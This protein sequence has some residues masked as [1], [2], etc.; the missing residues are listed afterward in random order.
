MLHH[1][2]AALK[3]SLLVVLQPVLPFPSIY[4]ASTI[5]GLAVLQGGS[6]VLC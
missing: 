6:V 5:H 4:S 2:R 1:S 3:S